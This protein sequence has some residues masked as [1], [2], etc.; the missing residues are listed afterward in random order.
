MIHLVFWLEFWV[1]VF[2]KDVYLSKKEKFLSC[3]LP[4]FFKHTSGRRNIIVILLKVKIVFKILL[5][6]K[7]YKILRLRT[8]I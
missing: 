8:A 2:L 4:Y 6:N 3:F 7:V 1:C 5:P